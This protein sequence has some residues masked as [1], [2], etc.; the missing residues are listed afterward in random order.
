MFNYLYKINPFYKFVTVITLAIL[1]TFTS[2][3]MLN[4][5]AFVICML[6]LITGS[7]KIVSALKLCVPMLLIATGLFISGANIGGSQQDGLFLATRVVAF[8]GFGM[9]FSLTTDP[10]AFMKS[11]QKDAKL[12]R[13]FAYGVLC[14]FNLVPYIKE[15]YNNARLALAVRGVKLSIFSVKPLFSVLVN[16]VRWS[17]MLSMAMQ[18]KGF[19]AE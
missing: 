10:Y 15:E 16:S 18:S 1:L 13:K 2:S 12:P 17:E 5:G 8:M 7:D 9:V 4:I 6:L 19:D 11:L 14:A 3:A